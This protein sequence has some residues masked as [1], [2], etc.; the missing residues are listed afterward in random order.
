MSFK[1]DLA[2]AR[3]AADIERRYNFSKRFS[4]VMGI[5]SG[6][7]QSADEAKKAASAAT[8]KLDE[9]LT[10]Q[11]IFNRLT[12][13]GE[14]QGI[15][16]ENGQIYFNGR[17]ILTR[18]F[19]SKGKCILEPGEED[20]VYALLHTMFGD[21]YP[22]PED[23]IKYFDLDG[24]GE[25]SQD[26]VMLLLEC[27]CGK[28]T[29]KDY[30][31]AKES[32]V[33]V[34][35]DPTNLEKAIKITSKNMWGRDVELYF[36]VNGT[37]ICTHRGDLAVGGKLSVGKAVK[38]ETNAVNEATL[39]LGVLAAPKKLSWKDNGDGTYTLIGE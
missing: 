25:V 13:N 2:G 24:D 1:Q 5:A 30:P 7:Q 14:A 18:S 35:I 3:T 39:A 37:N 8:G 36:G 31:F 6:A 23:Y 22:I 11:E 26:D 33:E 19:T 12:N 9:S 28:R 10:P 21:T 27:A 20:A 16:R 4:E 15:Y 38:F 32:E 34:I 17:Y 29:I